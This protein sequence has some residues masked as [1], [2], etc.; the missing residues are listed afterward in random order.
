[1]DDRRN[2]CVAVHKG[3]RLAQS[4]RNDVPLGRRTCCASKASSRTIRGDANISESRNIVGMDNLVPESLHFHSVVA[5]VEL[6]LARLKIARGHAGH[7]E[8]STRACTLIDRQIKGAYD[9]FER[10]I[11][12]LE[13]ERDTRIGELN[14][15]L[16]MIGNSRSKIRHMPDVTQT[17]PLP[18]WSHRGSRHADTQRRDE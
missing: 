16:A 17:V 10:S 7:S 4:H 14:S 5:I 13:N 15:A 8:R 9:D 3:S 18:R 1:M 11:R 12:Q 6:I 2:P